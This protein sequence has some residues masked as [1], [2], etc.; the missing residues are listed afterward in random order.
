MDFVIALHERSFS[1]MVLSLLHNW[2]FLLTRVDIRG[3]KR[4]VA[5]RECPDPAQKT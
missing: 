2:P 1:L 5:R 3:V 4:P